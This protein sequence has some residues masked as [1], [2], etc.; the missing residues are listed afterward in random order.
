MLPFPDSRP[1]SGLR[2]SDWN[3]PEETIRK[4]V[5]D[6]PARLYGVEV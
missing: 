5:Q 6:T 2:S 4:V 3:V 1:A